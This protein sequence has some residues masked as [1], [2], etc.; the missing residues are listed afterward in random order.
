MAVLYILYI[1]VVVVVVVVV[2]VVEVVMVVV[3]V[4][5][6]TAP[7]K[8]ATVKAATSTGD[9]LLVEERRPLVG[10]SRRLPR[11]EEV[12]TVLK[13]ESPGSEGCK[14]E[15]IPNLDSRLSLWA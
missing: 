5:Y 4:S 1:I 2:L 10:W 15:L 3:V 12:C 6:V 14:T 7:A 8:W 9:A 13:R 11:L